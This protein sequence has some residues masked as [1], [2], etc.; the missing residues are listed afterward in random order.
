MIEA[1]EM[2]RRFEGGERI[3]AR[4]EAMAYLVLRTQVATAVRRI[5]E[6]R[7]ERG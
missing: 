1:N 6:A 5:L 7:S 4:W 3:C 2:L